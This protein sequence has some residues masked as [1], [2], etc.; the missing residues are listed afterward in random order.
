MQKILAFSMPNC[1]TVGEE[2]SID[3]MWLYGHF[4]YF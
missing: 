4:S 1:C 2:F 3:K